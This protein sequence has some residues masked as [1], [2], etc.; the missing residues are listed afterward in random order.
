MSHIS[1]LLRGQD[2]IYN[3]SN[4]VYPWMKT[5]S[6]DLF[7]DIDGMG[8]YINANSPDYTSRRNR[9][10]IKLNDDDIVFIKLPNIDV[11]IAKEVYKRLPE[12]LLV[13]DKVEI[14]CPFYYTVYPEIFEHLQNVSFTDKTLTSER[15]DFI[16]KLAE[17][18]KRLCED[19]LEGF[20]NFL[21]RKPP[22]IKS[23]N[24]VSQIFN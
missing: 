1:Y 4:N 15:I 20:M 14:W 3:S 16:R 13:T 7:I 17:L 19:G 6:E 23:A 2:V 18:Q 9:L 5:E 24:S 11:E 22:N 10:T 21:I 12:Y 8:C